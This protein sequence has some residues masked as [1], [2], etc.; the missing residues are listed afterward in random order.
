MLAHACMH[1]SISTVLSMRVC[2]E[3]QRSNNSYTRSAK[4]AEV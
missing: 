2:L 1:M 3:M 4:A